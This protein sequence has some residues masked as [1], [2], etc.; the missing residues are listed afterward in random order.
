MNK[1]LSQLHVI[2]KTGV[3]FPQ[4][5]RSYT[6]HTWKRHLVTKLVFAKKKKKKSGG[7]NVSTFYIK[8]KWL[9]G[10]LESR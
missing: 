6:L 8:L 1:I 2:K 10:M 7:E 9:M 3:N 5:V 4:C